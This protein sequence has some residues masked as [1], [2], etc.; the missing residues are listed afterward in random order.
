[1]KKLII[2][3]VHAGYWTLYSLFLAFAV[4]CLQ[5]MNPKN[6][7]LLWVEI[8]FASLTAIPALLGFYSFYTVLFDRFLRNKQILKLVLFGGVAA[9]CCGISSSFCIEI[10]AKCHIGKTIFGDGWQSAYE[11]TQVMAFVA[12][13]NGGMGLV[14]RGFVSWYSDLESKLDL[15]KKTLL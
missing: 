14:L 11:I 2:A 10:L 4:L 5:Q 9:V 6:D 3:L 8:L 12:L 7:K 13:L 1:M 15:Q